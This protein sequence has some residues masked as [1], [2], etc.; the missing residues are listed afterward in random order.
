M[1]LSLLNTFDVLQKSV[2]Q[3]NDDLPNY[4]IQNINP[5]FEIR[6]YQKEA[7]NR[8]KFY[9][10]E[11]IERVKPTQ[12]L[13]QM[14]T[15]SGK[16]LIMAGCILQLYKQ[17]YRNFIFFVDSINIIEKTKDN[18]LNIR[19]E[20]HLFNSQIQFDAKAITLKQVENFANADADCIN[21]HFTTIQGLHSRLNNPK[22]N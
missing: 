20:E 19:S 8:F 5:K 17:G 1:A 7:L 6:E 18:F 9:L 10:N 21:I 12:L 13:F 22:E 2:K 11:Y 15:G 4:I 16:T 3:L 14:A